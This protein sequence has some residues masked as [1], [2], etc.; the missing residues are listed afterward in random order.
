MINDNTT[1][2]GGTV[3]FDIVLDTKPTA[4]VTIGLSSTDTTE[5]TISIGSVTLTEADWDI[6]QTVTIT[7]VDDS[8][9][10]GDIAYTIQ[11]SAATSADLNYDGI[12][13]LD[14]SVINFDDDV[15]E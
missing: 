4:D 8:E 1:E 12:D 7:G 10:G 14:V 2:A 13:P 6:A 11:T 9:V 15:V 5:G 3:T